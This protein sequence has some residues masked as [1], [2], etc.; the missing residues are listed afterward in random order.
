MNI[1][2]SG[3]KGDQNSQQE[4][5]TETKVG[6]QQI[7]QVETEIE[8]GKQQTDQEERGAE[9]KAG[10]QLIDQVKLNL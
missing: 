7:D 9:T 6:T 2:Y 8:S 10:T 4:T 1:D 5:G 3:S